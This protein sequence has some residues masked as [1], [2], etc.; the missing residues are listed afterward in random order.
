MFRI[1]QTATF[2]INKEEVNNREIRYLS[3][4]SIVNLDLSI[5]FF[6]NKKCKEIEIDPSTRYFLPRG[7]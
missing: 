6:K 3:D 2:D 5:V 4:L 1:R 7:K